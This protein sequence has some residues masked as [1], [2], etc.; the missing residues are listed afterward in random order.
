MEICKWICE[1][2]SV[3]TSPHPGHAVVFGHNSTLHLG[4]AGVC[5]RRTLMRHIQL[6]RFAKFIPST[7]PSPDFDWSNKARALCAT[8]MQTRHA[9]L[10]L[11][12]AEMVAAMVLVVFVV[13][14][15]PLP[16]TGWKVE[17]TCVFCLGF[18][19]DARDTLGT[20]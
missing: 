16:P 12:W 19:R 7:V 10:E 20:P 2:Y 3:Q 13:A 14:V 18:P 1:I 11:L 9:E 15:L 6:L 17:V 4:G 8:D 5:V